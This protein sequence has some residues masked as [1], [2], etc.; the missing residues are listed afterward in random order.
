MARD[1]AV[2]PLLASVREAVKLRK[3][4][5]EEGGV[6]C[7][8]HAS[9]GPNPA[10]ACH[11]GRAL[12]LLPVCPCRSTC[13][14]Y[15]AWLGEDAWGCVFRYGRGLSLGVLPVLHPAIAAS[16]SA[17]PRPA[18]TTRPSP[19]SLSCLLFY[20]F[21]CSPLCN[22]VLMRLRG[23]GRTARSLERVACWL[24]APAC[25]CM[26]ERACVHVCMCLCGH[27]D[28]MSPWTCRASEATP[29]WRK[30]LHFQKTA[31]KNGAGMV[32]GV[33][34]VPVSIFYPPSGRLGNK[35]K[36]YIMVA[37]A[38]CCRSWNMTR[39]LLESL[40]AMDDP[41]HV[42]VFDDASKVRAWGC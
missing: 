18:P 27:V 33:M 3:G 40:M 30:E 28:V 39:G 4:R 41:L 26:G 36:G 31:V 32:E 7:N 22:S 5:G 17:P 10:H 15:C 34:R 38:T 14:F 1:G 24:P 35:N 21:I 8:R 29:E 9:E 16:D 6:G 37:V 12:P 19:L 20:S 2:W 25:V 11:P 13:P 23:G 42:V